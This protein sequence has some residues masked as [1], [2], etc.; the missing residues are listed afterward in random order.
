VSSDSR[1]TVELGRVLPDGL[2]LEARAHHAAAPLAQ[3]VGALH[4]GRLGDVVVDA[5]R[6]LL[7]R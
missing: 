4:R 1:H 2:D 7:A 3:E 6:R 5:R